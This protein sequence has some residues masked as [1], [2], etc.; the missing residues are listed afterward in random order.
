[1][2]LQPVHARQGL[3]SAF[4]AWLTLMLL[5]AAAHSQTAKVLPPL[6]APKAAPAAEG[7]FGEMLRPTSRKAAQTALENRPYAPIARPDDEGQ[8]P[9]ID[10]FVGESRVFP[11][12]G[13]AR[14]A[15]GNGS[16]LTAAALDGKE[17]IL[18]ANGAGTSSLFVWHGDG[19]YQRLKINIVAGDASRQAREIAAFL[20]TIPRAKAT[21]VGSNVILEGEDLSD[22]EQA[23][24]DLLIQRYPQIVNFTNKIG[25]ERMVA[26]DV[27]VVEFPISL[28]R[29]V[30]LKWTSTGGAAL[31]GIWAPARRGGSGPYQV[32]IVTGEN[33]LPITGPDGTKPTLPSGL[34]AIAL[35]NLGLNAQ[36]NLLAQEGQASVLAEPQLTAR[37]GATAHFVAG[38]ELPYGVTTR[39]GTTIIF[40][41]Y[42]IK[43]DITP[44][45][46][47]SGAIRATI[48]AEVS[49][50]DSSVSTVFGPALIKR[51]TKTEF[52]LREGQTLVLSGLLQRDSNTTVDKVPVLG[53]LPVLGALFRSK[54]YQNKETELVIFVTPHFVSAESAGNVD[55][56]RRATERLGERAGPPPHLSEPLQPG[57]SYERPDAVPKPAPVPVPAAAASG[58]VVVAA[59]E[60]AAAAPRAEAPVARTPGGSR[61]V[62]TVESTALR[63]Q[64]NRS[65][66]M[67]VQLYRGATVLLGDADPQPPDSTAWRNV[68]VGAA[69]GW[70]PSAAVRPLAGGVGPTVPPAAALQAQAGTPLR[71]PLAQ[72][73]P[74]GSGAGVPMPVGAPYRVTLSGLALRVAPDMNAAV[75][76][77][78]REGTVVTALAQPQ[79]G[80]WTAVQWTDGTAHRTGWVSSQWIE[81]QAGR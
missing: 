30:G 37:N 60:A 5:P 70:V 4:I 81:P 57:V 78:M 80:A 8:I 68:V 34:N 26:M 76:L 13:V 2:T 3:P 72:G 73:L 63:T 17:I 10:M 48:D 7:G 19:R 31:A 66:P 41:E 46:G 12:P 35:L 55:R 64:P 56:I 61:L 33:G 29:E 11:T 50:V 58:P 43:L 75:I 65:S 71:R 36:L 24:V 27:K 45:V 49:S 28:L 15:V 25:W 9:E 22:E 42:G 32:N 39:D 77:Q 6:P 79:R 20:T 69:N 23:K 38:G 67:L 40:K 59:V 16:L 62:V 53:D 52:N 18:F 74:A 47:S 44:R 14:I 21:V 51:Q 54:R 1:M